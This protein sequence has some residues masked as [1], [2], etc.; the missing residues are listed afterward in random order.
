MFDDHPEAP[1][2]FCERATSGQAGAHSQN[3]RPVQPLAP[4]RVLWLERG[5]G[6]VLRGFLH[7][8][9]TK[10]V[11]RPPPPPALAS[12]WRA[13][14]P[15]SFQFCLKAWQ[16]ITHTPASPTYRKLKS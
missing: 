5:P 12:K 6:E 13:L 1:L 15:A 4:D 9:T 10:Y 3:G 11:L 7:Y 16:L 8:R 14:A 2:F